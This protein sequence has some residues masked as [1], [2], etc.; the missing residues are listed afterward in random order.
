[1]TWKKERRANEKQICIRKVRIYIAKCCERMSNIFNCVS[2]IAHTHWWAI[3]MG[4]VRQ[5][6]WWL[7]GNKKKKTNSVV[8]IYGMYIN[9]SYFDNLIINITYIFSLTFYKLSERK[10]EHLENI[11]II[12]NLSQHACCKPPMWEKEI[13][14][15]LLSDLMMRIINCQII[16]NYFNNI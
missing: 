4:F 10:K 1:M 6:C 11:I 15:R 7:K 16:Q 5:T 14:I 2:T 9:I 13:I 12:N 3:N 8:I